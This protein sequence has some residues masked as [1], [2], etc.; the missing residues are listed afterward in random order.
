MR[1]LIET[2]ADL[3]VLGETLFLRTQEVNDTH[4]QL[5]LINTELKDY[6]ERFEMA[7][8]S[9]KHLLT[10]AHNQVS[11][12][13]PECNITEILRNNRCSTTEGYYS[14][15]SMDEQ[16]TPVQ[17]KPSSKRPN[18][19]YTS[20]EDETETKPPP[21]K[22]KQDKT[23]SQKK[24]S[25]PIKPRNK[26]EIPIEPEKQIKHPESP[27]KK[28]KSKRSLSSESSY[29]LNYY[30]NVSMKKHYVILRNISTCYFLSNNISI[31][32]RKNIMVQSIMAYL[33][34]KSP[35]YAGKAS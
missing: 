22:S 8:N 27:R 33:M 4:K 9:L 11:A 26:D 30:L 31:H 1:Q 23:V 16:N 13:D 7:S 20:D 15:A 17:K 25:L 2:Q 18:I 21:K 10:V 12:I 34:Q 6:K 3:Q 32:Y 29:D 24:F 35:P 19:I 14:A 5:Q 28:K